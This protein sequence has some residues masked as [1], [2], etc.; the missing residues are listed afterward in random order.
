VITIYTRQDPPCSFCTRAKALLKSRDINFKEVRIGI[1]VTRESVIELFPN[2]KTIPIIT[3]NGVVIGGY[4]QLVTYLK[5]DNSSDDDK[6]L[7]LG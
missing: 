1:D 5:E 4:E 2:I 6:N 7:L 3:V